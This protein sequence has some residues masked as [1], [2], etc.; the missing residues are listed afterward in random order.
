MA[1][2]FKQLGLTELPFPTAPSS[3]QPPQPPSPPDPFA[4]ELARVADLPAPS[5]GIFWELFGGRPDALVQDVVEHPDRYTT[6]LVVLA[7]DIVEGRKKVGELTRGEAHLLNTG[8]L[9]F[10]QFRPAPTGATQKPQTKG[11]RAIAPVEAPAVPEVGVDI[12]E[13]ADPR[14]FWWT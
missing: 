2:L 4:P 6:E 11:P 5:R 12:P 7:Q 14:L 8:A 10:Y 9:E 13:G 1:L 3:P